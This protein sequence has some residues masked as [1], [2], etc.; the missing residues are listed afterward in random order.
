MPR[1]IGVSVSKVVTEPDYRIV[2]T[3]E[4]GDPFS[5]LTANGDDFEVREINP[6]KNTAALRLG[7]TDLGMGTLALN[8]A[9]SDAAVS[10]Y[11]EYPDTSTLLVAGYFDSLRVGPR[12][13]DAAVVPGSAGLSYSPRITFNTTL[14]PYLPPPGT[15]IRWGNE[16]YVVEGHG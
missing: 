2:V 9:L 12:W 10:I 1:I 5:L 14:F 4:T 7:N 13:V 15:V 16:D 6:D 8:G 3:P 11:K